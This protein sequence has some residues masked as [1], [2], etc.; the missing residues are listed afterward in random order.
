M[1]VINWL[2]VDLPL[3]NMLDFVS[4][5]DEIPNI[6][7][8]LKFMFETPTSIDIFT[9]NHQIDQVNVSNLAIVSGRTL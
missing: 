1:V 3:G 9:T 4:W 7:K 6:W 5:D 2:V 8:V